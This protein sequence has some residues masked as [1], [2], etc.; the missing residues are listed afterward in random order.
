MTLDICKNQLLPTALVN[1]M[2]KCRQCLAKFV[3]AA[4]MDQSPTEFPDSFGV[5]RFHKP[6]RSILLKGWEGRSMRW[7]PNFA[8]EEALTDNNIWSKMISNEVGFT[9]FKK[10]T[11]RKLYATILCKSHEFCKEPLNIFET[12]Q[13]ILKLHLVLIGCYICIRTDLEK[14]LGY[15][16]IRTNW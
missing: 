3:S 14:S 16:E 11:R 7:L 6:Y 8:N 15:I 10:Y 9:N 13:L 2:G 4:R 1:K 5:A 12:D